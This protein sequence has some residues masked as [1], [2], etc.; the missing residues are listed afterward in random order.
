MWLNPIIEKLKFDEEKNRTIRVL[1]NIVLCKSERQPLRL[2]TNTPPH[3]IHIQTSKG[4][5][6]GFRSTVQEGRAGTLVVLHLFWFSC[7]G[8]LFLRKYCSTSRCPHIVFFFLHYLNLPSFRQ[9]ETAKMGL[10][11]REEVLKNGISHMQSEA[12][13]LS[14][15]WGRYAGY[16][17][18]DQELWNQM[19]SFWLHVSNNI[20]VF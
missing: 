19:S 7:F 13:A 3:I 6:N 4:L 8:E 18:M 5:A 9:I 20:Y 2:V 10:A 17:A 1:N 15:R 14:R 12:L 11:E 16:S